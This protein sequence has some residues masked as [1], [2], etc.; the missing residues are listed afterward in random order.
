MENNKL[1]SNPIIWNKLTERNF[2]NLFNEFADLFN[3]CKSLTEKKSTTLYLRVYNL[4]IYALFDIIHY[5]GGYEFITAE[6]GGD[7][8]DN[9]K[10]SFIPQYHIIFDYIC[11][12]YL[13]FAEWEHFCREFY[14][15][16]YIYGCNIKDFSEVNLKVCIDAFFELPPPATL[17][18]LDI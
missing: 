1:H 16:C 13:T 3:I 17:T 4:L 2:N 15:R 14:Q 10:F 7:F 11:G 6:Y 9:E 8:A 18:D 12:Q 5:C